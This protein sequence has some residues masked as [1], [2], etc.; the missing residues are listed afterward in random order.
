MDFYSVMIHLGARLVGAYA[1]RTATVVNVLLALILGL[2]SSVEPGLYISWCRRKKLRVCSAMTA[3]KP[4]RV[5]C[6]ALTFSLPL[7]SHGGLVHGH[8]YQYTTFCAVFL[9]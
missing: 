4:E 1:N 8:L 6:R 3:N 9:F 7:A 5:F 2:D